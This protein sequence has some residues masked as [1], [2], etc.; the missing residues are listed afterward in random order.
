MGTIKEVI[1]NKEED[2]QKILKR[3]K[4]ISLKELKKEI[5]LQAD[6]YDNEYFIYGVGTKKKYSKYGIYCGSLYN[7]KHLNNVI[8][9]YSC[10]TG[11]KVGREKVLKSKKG[12]KN[13]YHLFIN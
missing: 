8:K 7:K 13:I 11:S 2:R 6:E 12:N 5:I 3:Q 9:V 1:K 10:R 4:K